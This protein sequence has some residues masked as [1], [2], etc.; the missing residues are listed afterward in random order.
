MVLKAPVP[1]T[2]KGRELPSRVA[3]QYEVDPDDDVRIIVLKSKSRDAANAEITKA[4]NDAS[5][6]AEANGLTQEKL[7]EILDEVADGV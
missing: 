2:I 7:E 3:K 5:A 6:Q 4:M 1:E